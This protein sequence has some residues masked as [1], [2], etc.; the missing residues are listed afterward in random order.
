MFLEKLFHRTIGIPVDQF[1]EFFYDSSF[2]PVNGDTREVHQA[3]WGSILGSFVE[4]GG[5]PA[6]TDRIAFANEL[7]AVAL[8]VFGLAWMHHFMSDEYTEEARDYVCAEIVSTQR[9]LER[10]GLQD[11]WKAMAAYNDAVDEAMLHPQTGAVDRDFAP[12]LS[13]GSVGLTT[14]TTGRK[15]R[16]VQTEA[17]QKWSTCIGTECS[18]RVSKRM[19]KRDDWGGRP[20]ARCLALAVA[21]RLQWGIGLESKVLIGLEAMIDRLY[22]DSKAAIESATLTK[23]NK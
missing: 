5:V 20:I 13:F 10:Y 14:M 7:T 4:A 3:L 11:V 12:F 16:S 19:S 9:Y 23:P 8:E 15:L 21:R 6:Q 2:F 18:N 22:N 1:C 17:M